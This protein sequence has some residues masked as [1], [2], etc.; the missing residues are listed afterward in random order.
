M[1]YQLQYKAIKHMNIFKKISLITL[2]LLG[3]LRITSAAVDPVTVIV[4]MAPPYT[5]Y[6]SE[7][8]STGVSKMQVTLIVNDSRLLNYPAKLQMV[9]ENVNGGGVIMQTNQYAAIAPIMLTGQTTELLMGSD[10]APYFMAQ[11]NIFAGID[12]TQYIQTGRIPDGQ[13]RIGFRVVDAQRSDVILSNTAYTQP[14]WFLLN[15]PPLLNLPRNK[16]EQRVA[17]PQYIKLEWYPRHLGSMNTAFAASYNL[18]LYPIRVP[19]MDANQVA[20]SMLPAYT[21]TTNQTRLFLT[22]DKYMLE[23]GVEYAWRVQAFTDGEMTLFQN[24]GYSEV[25]SFVYGSLCP[26]PENV[27]ADVMGPERVYINWDADPMHTAF[28]L[29]FRVKDQEDARWHTRESYINSVELNN[30][31]S[32][33]TTYEYQVKGKA[34]GVESDYTPLASFTTTA[35]QHSENFECGL[36]DTSK[37]TNYNPKSTLRIGDV[38]YNGDFPIKLTEVTGS[39]GVFTGKGRMRIPFLND[40]RV[41]MEFKN[42]KI[43][44]LNQVY[45]GKL[46][47]VYNPNS[48]FYVDDV[49]DYWSVGDQVGNII[50]GQEVANI[51]TDFVIS[52]TTN[53]TVNYTGNNVT[54]TDNGSGSMATG[55]VSTTTGG[56]TIS[57][58]NGNLF[59]VNKEGE[60]KQ[61]GKSGGTEDNTD[62][63]TTAGTYNNLSADAKI[64]FVN[65]E[66]DLWAFD[67]W[68]ETYQGKTLV[69]REYENIGDY[70]VPWK[71]IP[72][73]KSGKLVAKVTQGDIDLSKVVF[74]TPAGTEYFSEETQDGLEITVVGAEHGDGQEIYALY[75]QDDSTTISLGKVKVASYDML[76][77]K[78]HIVAIDELNVNV[79]DVETNVNKIFIQYGVEWDVKLSKPFTDDSWDL[80]EDKM[81][82]AGESGMFTVYT[83]EMKALNKTYA[84]SNTIDPEAMYLFIIKNSTGST[85]VL[86]GDMPIKSQFGY[87]FSP[88]ENSI[89]AKTIAHELAHGM[90]QLKHTFDE[91]YGFDKSSTNNL[92]DYSNGTHLFK[93]QWDAMYDQ[94]A[95]LFAWLQGDEEGKYSKTDNTL[96]LKIL[97][98]IQCAYLD[99]HNTVDIP[100]ILRIEKNFPTIENIGKVGFV[101][102]KNAGSDIT[103]GARANSEEG[104]YNVYSVT[105]SSRGMTYKEEEI[106]KFKIDL[107][108]LNLYTD[109]VNA[110]LS[111]LNIDEA[112]LKDQIDK[113]LQQ[114]N[115]KSLTDEDIDLL[116]NHAACATRFISPENKYLLIKAIL[117]KNKQE[118]AEDLVL[119]ILRTTAAGEDSKLL[120]QKIMQDAELVLLMANKINNITYIFGIKGKGEEDNLDRFFIE[121][122]SLYQKA[123]TKEELE[124]IEKNIKDDNRYYFY[125]VQGAIDQH[126]MCYRNLTDVYT[127][128]GNVTIEEELYTLI[129]GNTAGVASTSMCNKEAIFSYEHTF[130][131]HIVVMNA[132]NNLSID[133]GVYLM[134]AFAYYLL[135]KAAKEREFQD[136]INSIFFVVT[137]ATPYDEY[138]LLGKALKYSSK[139]LKSIKFSKAKSILSNKK[140]TVPERHLA[141][142]DGDL[143]KISN[144]VEVA[145]EVKSIDEL[146]ALV[147]DAHK[148]ALRADL[149]ASKEF[150]EALGRNTELVE[151]W[152]KVSGMGID[153]FVNQPGYIQTLQK[154]AKYQDE[155]L[156]GATGNVK[157][158]RVQTEHPLSKALSVENNNLVFHKLDNN[159]N[160]STTSRAHADYYAAKKM[161]KGNT[162]EIIEFEVPKSVDIQMK[163]AAVPQ[164]K[165]PTNLIN[166]NGTASKIVDPLQPGDPFELS[167]Y[168][169][170]LIEQNYIKGSAKIVN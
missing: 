88:K 151:S 50:T 124:A 150:A 116:K 24:N 127:T 108:N 34:P 98:E 61:V 87:I 5:P 104:N 144:F 32:A 74:K 27:R 96:Y 125:E 13:Y 82:D 52:G 36:Q 117:E 115:L 49:T 23:P 15:D 41:N 100:Y 147:D 142:F 33:N 68:N 143:G 148:A 85:G 65:A 26:V 8:A 146:V 3:T 135:I 119:D 83:D 14:G 53:I 81:L 155:A 102:E 69:E 58:A 47:S 105:V 59:T 55:T 156:S 123:Y 38:I 112:A 4:T 140:L 77:R 149:L 106:F 76:V 163:Q 67:A 118:Y 86:L 90:F 51:Q 170:Q 1:K 43:N 94:Q 66:G 63:G 21:E 129:I 92:M 2:L 162:V 22:P 44:E 79:D 158:Y 48:K 134:P 30:L 31:L 12:Q 157:Y 10:L 132:T 60:V 56:T 75:P 25:Y 101:R 57:D 64:E 89:T 154:I 128:N 120:Y 93:Q 97:Q 17:E 133:E 126:V 54:V 84:D 166:K 131:E 153:D 145:S 29:R 39:N 40:V 160:I 95:L 72:A 107:G 113:V 169:L 45:E 7:Y 159:L 42:I 20:L 9:I 19:G 164:Y 80:N 46:T 62:Y 28:E 136:K 18:E 73:G 78:L 138:Y 71:L 137:I 103:L 109:N 35:L 168:W 37:I 130:D 16:E 139:G 11:N 91:D 161:E 114:I 121:L 99:G 165:A 111:Y 70:R 141:Q 167:P 6:I 110:L 152:K 122:M